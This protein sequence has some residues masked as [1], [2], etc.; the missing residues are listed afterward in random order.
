VINPKTE[1]TGHSETSLF[2]TTLGVTSQE[3]EMFGV[4]T[5]PGRREK[6]MGHLNLIAAHSDIT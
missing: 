2:A 6:N 5:V 4:K 1:T 3:R